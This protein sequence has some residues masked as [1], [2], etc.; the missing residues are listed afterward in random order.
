MD[1]ELLRRLRTE[2]ARALLGDA[3]SHH[4]VMLAC[5]RRRARLM[6]TGSPDRT[7]IALRDIA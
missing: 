2:Q 5:D 6:I 7:A 3:D 1:D 4:V